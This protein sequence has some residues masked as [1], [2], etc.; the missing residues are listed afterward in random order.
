MHEGNLSDCHT[1]GRIPSHPF[2]ANIPHQDMLS[3][4]SFVIICLARLACLALYLQGGARDIANEG[5]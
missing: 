4:V 2:T 5:I 1:T 3:G